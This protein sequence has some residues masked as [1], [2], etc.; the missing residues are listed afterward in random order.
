MPVV[1]SDH[2]LGEG[3]EEITV[4]ICLQALQRH[5]T[6]GRIIADQAFQLVTAMGGDRD[7]GVQ[8]K[9]MHAG[10]AGASEGRALTLVAKA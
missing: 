8:R 5:S 2:G 9:P 10:T 4:G 3:V 7:I 1:P 6:A